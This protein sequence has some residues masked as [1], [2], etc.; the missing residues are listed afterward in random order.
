MGYDGEKW[1]AAAGHEEEGG[2][3]WGLRETFPW[4]WEWI[5]A[6]NEPFLELLGGEGY[7][8][9]LVIDKK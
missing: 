2:M 5:F 8:W 9:E 3:Q 1:V 7:N 4:L 6:M